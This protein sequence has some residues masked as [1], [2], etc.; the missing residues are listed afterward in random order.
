[1][2]SYST[3]IFESSDE[4]IKDISHW[5]EDKYSQKGSNPGGIHYDETGTKHYVK[6]YSNPDHAK[7]ELASAK[8]HQLL[9]VRTVM[10]DLIKK[11]GKIGLASVYR[12]DL[13]VESPYFY[14]N[15]KPH[16]KN[17]ITKMY[18]AAI[19]TNNRDIVGLEH[20]NIMVDKK[21]GELHSLDQG[22]S[23]SFRAQGG[24]K[25]FTDNIDEK[26]SLR[27]YRPAADVFNSNLSIED[28]RANI[29]NIK[30]VKDSDIKDILKSSGL[31][32]HE[33]LANIIISRKNKLIKSYQ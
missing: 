22:G 2:K 16:Q 29:E 18:H 24:K 33:D 8:L 31:S 21:T 6:L 3:F 14:D 27:K 25:E 4:K 10:P 15:L 11:N 26:D 28:E 30:Q 32:N 12:D 19:I 5:R 13:K 23:F 17:D 7:T 9:G 20:D 1:M